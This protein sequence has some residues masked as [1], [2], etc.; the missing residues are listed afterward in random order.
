M[1][2]NTPL[3]NYF[4]LLAQ[5]RRS[6][7]ENFTYLDN[8]A[9]THKP[10]VVL[11]AIRDFYETSNS[12]V[13]RGLYPLA[14]QATERFESARETVAHFLGAPA[15]STIFTSGATAALNILSLGLESLFGPRD[16]ILVS[17]LE[18]HANYLPWM[19]LAERTGAQFISVPV[20]TNGTLDLDFFSA[21]LKSGRVK[22]FAVTALSHVLGN[23]LPVQ[24][25]FA[26]ARAAGALTVLDAA[27][28]VFHC[29]G[30][31][32]ALNCDALV[33]S[34]HKVFAPSGVGVLAISTRLADLLEPV[35]LGGGMVSEVGT[36]QKTSQWRESPH[37]FEGGTPP[38][39]GAIA[40]AV[41]LEFMSSQ[42]SSPEITASVAPLIDQLA[43]HLAL[44]PDVELYGWASEVKAAAPTKAPPHGDILSFNLR[45]HH[46][47]DIAQLCADHGVAVRAGSH[48][49]QPLMKRFKIP[50]AVRVS[51][52][53]YNDQFDIDHLLHALSKVP[54]GVA[55]RSQTVSAELGQ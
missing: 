46:A 36:S 13:H 50:G 11:A 26:Q 30:D 17:D 42:V 7:G 48:C 53:P 16:V 2:D 3:R 10:A 47:H 38:L 24:S 33:F 15:A 41:A 45:G 49:A 12:N 39:S 32:A 28:A 8:A 43:S 44:R 31:F 20:L 5:A 27:Q 21:Q 37:C 1:K 9:T 55:A 25:L 54:L 52:A 4:P 14:E 51:L 6:G 18:H 29:K 19:R 34:G 22:I 35:M 40:L 23:V